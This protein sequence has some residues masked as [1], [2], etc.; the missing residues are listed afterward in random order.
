VVPR[1]R[2]RQ[3][4]GA[5]LLLATLALLA[6]VAVVAEG[7]PLEAP[8]ASDR[9]SLDP[10]VVVFAI[11]FVLLVAAAAVLFAL[12]SVLGERRAAPMPRAR[13]SWL[14]VL[15]ALGAVGLLF[16]LPDDLR[17]LPDNQQGSGEGSEGP[18]PGEPDDGPSP[19]VWPVV[20]L[21]AAFAVA[22]VGAALGGRRPRELKPPAEPSP[23]PDVT[24]A[25][26]AFDASLVELEAEPDPRQAV[27][28]AYASLLAGLERAGVPRR[29]EEAPEEHLHRAL[30]ALDVP[31]APLRS[32]VAL[33]AEARF[34]THQIGLDHKS[35]A[36]DAFRS[37]RD[38]LEVRAGAP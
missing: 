38:A 14:H 1:W 21:G 10:S 18:P 20:V 26:A 22:M 32:L 4:W 11:G 33:F 7:T 37:A 35:A 2:P 34:S 19:P 12:W 36:L 9:L 13:R 31:P 30:A 8:R 27:I 25:R 16:A 23:V 3:R 28:A 15:V 5:G 24:V 6:L 17:R 29:L